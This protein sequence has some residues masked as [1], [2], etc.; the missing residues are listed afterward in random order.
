VGDIRNSNVCVFIVY[1]IKSEE[2]SSLTNERN[3]LISNNSEG[4]RI[5]FRGIC[6]LKGQSVLRIYTG[7]KEAGHDYFDRWVWEGSNPCTLKKWTVLCVEWVL[8]S[9]PNSTIMVD[10]RKICNFPD[11]GLAGSYTNFA[12]GNRSTIAPSIDGRD[13]RGCIAR[14]EIY[15]HN[16]GTWMPDAVKSAI[17]VSLCRQYGIKPDIDDLL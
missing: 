4:T 12:I 5:D 10:G 3:F 13:F 2:G 9:N 7:T 17:S 14:V 1:Q 8:N 6:F 16:N 11:P 15:K